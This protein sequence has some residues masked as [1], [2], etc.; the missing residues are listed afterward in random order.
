MLL[1]LPE[2]P[3]APAGV[4]LVDARTI[5]TAASGF[6]RRYRYTLNPYSGCRFACEYCYARAFAPTPEKRETWGEWVSAKQNAAALIA[7]ACRDGKLL[8]GDAVYMSSATDPYQPAEARLG[9]TR[10]ILEAM[11]A[12][13]VQPRLTVQTRSPIAARDIDLFQRF[14]HI[15][16]NFTI[17]TDSER[18]RLRYEPSAPAIHAG[19]RAARSL[20]EAGVPIGVSISPMLPIDDIEG[21]AATVAG[22]GAAE[23]VAQFMDPPGP[24]FAAGTRPQ[25]LELAREDGWGLREYAAARQVI[26][27]AL[28]PGR[29]LLEGAEGFAPAV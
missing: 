20:V 29:R 14:E 25:T 1:A 5:L 15:R 24:A 10:A 19:L 17:T 23:Y 21:F 9:V 4:T 11:L 18:V 3:T 12:A 28:S 13:G 27:H 22:L 2:E 16:V 8:S 26:Q 7:K 6:I